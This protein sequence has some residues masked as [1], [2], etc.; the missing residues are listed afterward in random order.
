MGADGARVAADS[1]AAAIDA[2]ESIVKT[3][4]IDCEFSRVDGWLFAGEKD[5][6]IIEKELVAA[7]NAGLTT[8]EQQSQI[9]GVAFKSGAC[10]RFPNQAR[11]HPMK[12][13][14]GLA[15]AAEKHGAR[16]FAGTHVGKVEGGDHAQVTTKNG[17]VVKASAIVVA[18]NT[19]VNDIVSIHTK[20]AAYRSYVVAMELPKGAVPDALFWDIEDPF[21]YVRVERHDDVDLLL[22]GGEDH[23]TGQA[24]DMTSR[25]ER[26]EMWARTR[27]PVTTTRYRWS[28]QVMESTD[29]LGYIGRNPADHDNVF[30]CTGD[31]GNGLTHG[32]IAGLLLRDLISDI[33][34]P[35]AKV[36]SPSRLPAV[37]RFAKENV[38]VAAQYAD[39]VKPSEVAGAEDVKPGEGAVIRRGL[40]MV[41][42]SCGAD[43][44][45]R[46]CSAVC[47]HLGAI[48]RWNPGEQTW[49][50]PAHG[51]R[52]TP[53]GE[54][55]NGPAL[56]DLKKP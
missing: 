47:P 1:H 3:E 37:A 53:S 16:I 52:F 9:P 40:S 42:V 10:L 6:S 11:F 38:N 41:A 49:D 28:G 31:S 26:L 14:V 7:R 32:T 13:L 4:Q 18:T 21:H 46:E 33:E 27:F 19:P 2:I 44:K 25:Y 15:H 23:K 34:S 39:W 36:Y 8:V 51:S 22:V 35:W 12:Y 50:C 45:R 30:I 55:V 5:P 48:L 20:Q 24:D 17:L 54:V 43:G 29:G 56:S